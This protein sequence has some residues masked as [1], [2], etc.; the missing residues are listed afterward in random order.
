MSDGTGTSLTDNSG[1]GN[2]GTLTNGPVWKMSGCF[3]GSRQALDFDGSN[4]YVDPTSGF[5]N[6]F[7]N[8]Q[9]FSFWGW[10]YHTTLN[11]SLWGTFFSRYYQSQNHYRVTFNCLSNSDSHGYDDIFFSVSNGPSSYGKAFTC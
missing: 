4:D 8:L 5:S 9:R 3:A 10:V 2:T 11:N 1:K 6:A 7:D